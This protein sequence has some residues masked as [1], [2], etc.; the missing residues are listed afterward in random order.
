MKRI[1]TTFKREKG[2]GLFCLS[3]VCL[4]CRRLEVLMGGGEKHSKRKEIQR[5]RRSR[6]ERFFNLITGE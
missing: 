3:F 1:L 5:Y 2:G 6:K 4:W